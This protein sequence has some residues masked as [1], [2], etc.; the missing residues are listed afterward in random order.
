MKVQSRKSMLELIRDN[1]VKYGHH[2]YLI[3]GGMLPRYAY[4]IGLREAIGAELILA[5][6]S[7]YSAEDVKRIINE[8]AAKLRTGV[9]WWK[10]ALEVSSLGLFS[11][12]KVDSSWAE[13]LMLGALDFYSVR[14]LEAFQ[15]VPDQN[16]SSIDVPNFAEPW[17]ATAEPVWQ[18]LHE[19]WRYV[20]PPESVA[21]TNL[22]ALRGGRITEAA[23]W[24]E[25]QW[26]LFSGAGP[27]VPRENIRVVPL[28]TLLAVDESLS[29]ITNLKVGRALWR[30]STELEWHLWKECG[31]GR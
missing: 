19:P 7:F 10:S 24:E 5:G 6:A 31:K 27:D 26:E 4:T 8:V 13:A 28:G 17:S 11:P 3:P 22:D 30:D 25:D 15:I 29:A 23:R 20:V 9:D 12:R 16:H 14:K 21:I 18:W 2:I 1:I